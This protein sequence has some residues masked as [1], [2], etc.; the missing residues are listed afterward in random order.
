MIDTHAHLT[1]PLFDL[2]RPAVALRAREAGIQGWVEI[3]AAEEDW[4]KARV[5]AQTSRD[6]TDWPVVYWAVG[7]HPYEVA[8][9]EEPLLARMAQALGDPQAVAVGEVG[10]DYHREALPRDLQRRVF[11]KMAA[12]ARRFEKPLV[13]HCRELRPADTAAQKD[14]LDILSQVYPEPWSGPPRGVAHCFQGSL[15]SAQ[16]LFRQ[17]FFIGLD[18][19]VTYPKATV[20]RELA[21]SLP[22]EAL[23]L[24]TD[25]PY[26]PP[27]SR[28]GQRNEPSWIPETALALAD[29]HHQPLEFITRQTTQNACSLFRRNFKRS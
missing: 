10:L 25:A 14:L 6:N 12:L 15:D 21:A 17:G 29:L 26:L 8:K 16:E 23:V 28:R 5:L 27:Q 20:L 4:D 7:F 1:D 11:E 13:I 24:E 19:P 18:A 9:F 3:A 2:D 22:L